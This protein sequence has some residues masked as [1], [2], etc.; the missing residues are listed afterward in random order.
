MR[1]GAE[2]VAAFQR[3]DGLGPSF[4]RGPLAIKLAVVGMLVAG[5]I[6]LFVA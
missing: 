2:T 4:L 3:V 6:A 5:T 1:G